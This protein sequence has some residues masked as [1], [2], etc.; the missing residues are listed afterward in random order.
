MVSRSKIRRSSLRFK[1][2]SR[3]RESKSWSSKSEI[4]TIANFVNYGQKNL[5]SGSPFHVHIFSSLLNRL[6]L[7]IVTLTWPINRV[8]W[9]VRYINT[10]MLQAIC[11]GKVHLQQGHS[12]K[13]CGGPKYFYFH[14]RGPEQ[15]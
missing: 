5:N 12:I 2:S 13:F 14:N 4:L 11:P 8:L 6:K 7:F 1:N 15:F 10:N 9:F 3:Y